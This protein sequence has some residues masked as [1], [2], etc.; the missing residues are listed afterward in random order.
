M[1]TLSKSDYLLFLKHPA[2]LWLK[3]HDKSKLTPVSENLQAI[4]DAG[5]DFE[6]YAEQ[7]FEDGVRIGFSGYDEYLTQ[8]ART[9]RAIDDGIRT[10]FQG[11]FE[12]NHITCICDVVVFIDAHTVDLYEI[13]SSTEAKLIH[14]HDLAFQMVVLESCGYEV[15]NITVLC[16][17]NEFVRFGEIDPKQL[18]LSQDVTNAVVEKREDTKSHIQKAFRVVESMTRPD[19]SPSHCGFGSLKEWLEIYRTLATVSVGSIYDLCRLNVELISELESHSISYIAD[20]PDDIA[21]KSQ[22]VLQVR[23]SKENRVIVNGDEIR[24]FLSRFVFPL[25]FL[26]Y[27]TLSSTVPIFDGTKPYQQVPFQ[28][29][30]HILDSPSAQARHIGYLHDQNSNPVLPLTQSLQNAIGTHGTI[31]VWFEAFEKSRNSEMGEQEPKFKEFYEHVNGRV[32]DLMTPFSSG[33]YAHKDF[34]G[35]AS[36]KKVLPVLIPELS[37]SGLDVHEGAT[38]QRLWMETILEGKN[39][40]DREKILKDL[41]VYCTLDTKAMVKIYEKLSEFITPL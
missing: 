16:V 27:E 8:P 19:I 40:D 22:Q 1:Y 30:L 33:W 23:V 37:Y 39:G 28:Y 36:I 26:D 17:N 15:R 32:V 18:V 24:N 38:A 25:Y 21:L 41:D 13:K 6:T 10:I 2:W 14:E 3:K 34:L 11:R 29:S 7:L 20:I 9:K 4:F 31:L 12:H 5:N 35:S